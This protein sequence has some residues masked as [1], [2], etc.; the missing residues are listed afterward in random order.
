[1][2]GGLSVIPVVGCLA[3]GK[4]VVPGRYG[5]GLFPQ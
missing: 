4:G 5:T 1:M 2:L 3:L